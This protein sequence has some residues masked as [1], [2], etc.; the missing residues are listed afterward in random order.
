MNFYD[1]FV[2]NCHSTYKDV[3]KTVA[4]SIKMGQQLS[5]AGSA[6]VRYAYDRVNYMRCEILKI[7]LSASCY[8]SRNSPLILSYETLVPDENFARE[9]S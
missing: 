6:S 8:C 7:C 5:H 9:V 3:F 2:R 4:F 1:G